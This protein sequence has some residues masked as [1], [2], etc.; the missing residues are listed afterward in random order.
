[1]GTAPALGVTASAGSRRRCLFVCA[2]FCSADPLCSLRCAIHQRWQRRQFQASAMPLPRGE[3]HA[4]FFRAGRSAFSPG[5]FLVS[6]Y[7]FAKTN[8]ASAQLW[9][10]SFSCSPAHLQLV[11]ELRGQARHAASLRPLLLPAAGRRWQPYPRP[12]GSPQP[13]G[14]ED[15][16]A[17]RWQPQL[18]RNT[19]M[20]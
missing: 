5:R 2:P 12:A 11:S 14:A 10:R 9:A 7:P 13:L 19:A 15:A 17:R 8:D 20:G 6:L 18:G 16:A 4:G 1:M 3:K